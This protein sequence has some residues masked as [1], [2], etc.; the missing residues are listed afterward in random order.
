MLEHA[1]IQ[2]ERRRLMH[3]LARRFRRIRLDRGQGLV[4]VEALTKA[5]QIQLEI[6]GILRESGFG[7]GP[8]ILARPYLE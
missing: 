7:I 5:R 4:R 2:K 3:A 6:R 1:A 8:H